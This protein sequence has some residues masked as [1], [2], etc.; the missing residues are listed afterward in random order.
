M[1]YN[2]GQGV[3][4]GTTGALAGSQFGPVGTGIGGILG[5]LGGFGSTSKDKL[6]QLPTMTPGQQKILDQLSS[7]LG[8]QGGLG[9][10]YGESL[11]LLRD[12]LD[13]S[14]QSFQKF[15]DPYMREFEQQTVPM[16]AERF[17]GM[18]GGM[19][20]G[21]SSSGFGQAL[22]AAGGNLQSQLAALKA[23]LAS[24]AAQQLM[25]QYGSMTGQA[26]GARPFGYQFQQGGPSTATNAFSGYAGAGF[27]GLGQLSSGLSDMYQKYMPLGSLGGM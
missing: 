18:G 17:A 26:L 8:P 4:S 16:L 25:G 11:D 10:G 22:G 13:P 20:G 15:A 24:G 6:K 23:Q 27:P 2:W 19:G 1:G 5:L 3:A 9:S 7:L 12:Y 14:G 21:L